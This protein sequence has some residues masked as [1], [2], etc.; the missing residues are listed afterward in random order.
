M[1]KFMSKAKQKL[2]C[3]KGGSYFL[4]I[5]AALILVCVIISITSP[6]LFKTSEKQVDKVDSAIDSMWDNKIK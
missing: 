5:V 6:K 1:K 3:K 4:Q 2:A